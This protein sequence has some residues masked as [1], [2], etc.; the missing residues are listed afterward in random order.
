[1]NIGDFTVFNLLLSYT[2]PTPQL[3]LVKHVKFDLNI[4]N[5]FDRH[6]FSYYY[7]QIPPSPN[8]YYCAPAYENGLPGE[9]FGVNFTMTAR[10]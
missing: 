6:Y 1:L 9:P 4:Q 8:C 10:F 2:L 3:P 7:S 5:L